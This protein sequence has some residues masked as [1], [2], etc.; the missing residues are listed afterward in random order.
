VGEGRRGY[1]PAKGTWEE[2]FRKEGGRW[3][4]KLPYEQGKS[5]EELVIESKNNKRK[6][7]GKKEGK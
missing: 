6:R 1:L 3:E 2:S 7:R 5:A 4:N